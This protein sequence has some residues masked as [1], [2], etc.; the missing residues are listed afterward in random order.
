MSIE[1]NKKNIQIV[2]RANEAYNNGDT[3]K[4]NEF[5][6]QEYFNHESQSD[7]QRASLRGSEEFINTLSNLRMP[8]L[9]F[10]MKKMTSFRQKIKLL[11]F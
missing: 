6:G 10:T 3:S 4:V 2:R 7:P 9:I 5:I 11:W 1:V 8:S